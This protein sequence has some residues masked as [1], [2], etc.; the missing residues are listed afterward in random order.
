MPDFWRVVLGPR[1]EHPE[2]VAHNLT[3]KEAVQIRKRRGSA[4]HY[5][6]Q[7]EQHRDVPVATCL[8][9]KNENDEFINS[10]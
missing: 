1:S 9:C 10:R 7:N 6:K 5:A 4:A 8:Q 2:F 3:I